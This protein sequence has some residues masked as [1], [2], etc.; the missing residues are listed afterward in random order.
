MAKP[1]P[2]LCPRK[3]ARDSAPLLRGG[4]LRSHR[5]LIPLGVAE[6]PTSWPVCSPLRWLLVYKMQSDYLCN[7]MLICLGIIFLFALSSRRASRSSLSHPSL[8]WLSLTPVMVDMAHDEI[9]TYTDGL[10]PRTCQGSD[11]GCAVMRGRWSPI[12]IG[13]CY[14]FM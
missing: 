7:N 2:R 1:I 5:P 12:E 10:R 11:W 9:L 3:W 6:S 14:T 4:T 13:Q 8:R